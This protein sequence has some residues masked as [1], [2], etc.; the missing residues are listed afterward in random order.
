MKKKKIIEFKKVTIISEKKT[1]Y[2]K[3]KILLILNPFNFFKYIADKYFILNNLSFKIN[4]GEVIK[5]T[6]STKAEE[7]EVIELLHNKKKHKFGKVVIKGKVISTTNNKLKKQLNKG[8]LNLNKTLEKVVDKKY[9]KEILNIC[10]LKSNQKLDGK[11]INKLIII[12]TLFQN[13]DFYLLTKY[14]NE[15]KFNNLVAKKIRELKKQNKTIILLDNN[16]N[17]N[18][19][20]YKTIFIKNGHLIENRADI[21]PMKIEK[22]VKL[23]SNTYWLAYL[24][25]LISFTIIPLLFSYVSSSVI[26]LD[27][28]NLVFM[29]SGVCL[30]SLIGLIFNTKIKKIFYTIFYF[31]VLTY[32]LIQ[33]FTV[34]TLNKYFSVFDLSNAEEATDFL[35]SIIPALNFKFY[36]FVVIAISIY[37]IT[38]NAIKHSKFKVINNKHLI[39]KY[40]CVILTIV[41]I[42]ILVEIGNLKL[43][44]EHEELKQEEKSQ[45]VNKI[46][47]KEI[48]EKFV[49]KKETM[50][51]LH[52]YRY[53][54][55]DIVEYNNTLNSKGTSTGEITNYIKTVNK[56]LEP[57]QYTGIAKDENLI[58][59]LLESVDTWMVTEE[60]APTLYNI[61]KEGMNFTNHY[62]INYN[63]GRTQNTEYTVNTGFYIPSNYDVY[64][65]SKYDYEYSL[66]NLFNNLG[67]RTTSIHTNTGEY[68]QRNDFHKSWGYQNSNFLLDQGY[69]DEYFDDRKLAED[70]IYDKYISKDE[71][72]MSSVI[73]FIPHGAYINNRFCDN[74]KEEIEC[75]TQLMGM[76]DDYIKLLIEKLE[77]DNLLD[78]TTLV[79]YGD[80]YSYL[81]NDQ[82]YLKEQK[83]VTDENIHEIEK[84]PFII[85]NNRM[86]SVTVD[87]YTDSADILPTVAN[88]FGLNFNPNYYVGDDVFSKTYSNYV[89]MSDGSYIGDNPNESSKVDNALDINNK[90]IKSNYFLQE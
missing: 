13:Y 12:T 34:Y 24:M 5:I 57:N 3:N 58:L 38:L 16:Y 71:K 33:Y 80:H 62:A 77:E 25:I 73:T 4:L 61:Q 56:S 41:A 88:I 47:R 50:N 54:Y 46:S 64:D 8:N 59:I 75:Y 81:Y 26:K 11:D 39:V 49:D 86:E 31:L 63:G 21:K 15:V 35:S 40:I 65:S 42:P 48:V 79:L 18:T 29:F 27:I 36:L 74:K 17:Y 2:K 22:E 70:E 78:N 19:V 43:N 9:I 82:E 60:I 30:F 87:T 44:E 55:L 6:F 14:I 51:I 84:V 10:N 69:G 66:P 90:I 89:L 28:V 53:F 52:L 1:K 32:S 83:G 45:V 20:K 72:F 76:L 37:I 23:Y 85:W 67:Y 68:Y 7:K